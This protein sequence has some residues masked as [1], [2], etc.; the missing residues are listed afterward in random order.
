MI[1]YPAIDLYDGMAV[2]LRQGRY[3]DMT[4]YDRDPKSLALRMRDAGATH[5]HM[6]DL[7]GARSGSTVNL[8]LIEQIAGTSGLFIELGGGIRSMDTIRRYLDC[9]I[10]RAIL[11]TAAVEDESLLREALETFGEQIAVGVDLKD[12]FVAV[13]GWEEKSSWTAE[14]FFEH[15]TELDVRT[16]ICTDISRDGVLAGSNHE[17]YETLTARFPI[18]LIAS[19]GVSSLDDIWGLR[20]LGMSGAILGRA[21]YSGAVSL[22]EALTA[23]DGDPVETGEGAQL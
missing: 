3:D 13:R 23:A 10:S 21:Y 15:L 20:A 18:D 16:V 12:G 14:T 9:G 6:V 19:G 2:R 5:L 1:L 11:G 7:E 17:L 4:V 8:R 22:E